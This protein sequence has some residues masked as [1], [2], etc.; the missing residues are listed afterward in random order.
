MI[1]N[2]LQQ[3]MKALMEES[4]TSAYRVSRNIGRSR[5]YVYNAL[6]TPHQSISKGLV[7]IIEGLGYD[8]QL[9]F[10]PRDVRQESKAYFENFTHG[11]IVKME[12]ENMN[13]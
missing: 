8:I 13:A 1:K 7:K 4:N 5:Q 9:V 10:V 2:N 3:D 6:S 11:V 12:K